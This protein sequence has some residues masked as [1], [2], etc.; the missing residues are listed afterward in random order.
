MRAISIVF[1]RELGAY[2]RSPLGYIVGAAVLLLLGM[3]FQ[4]W[5]LS[6]KPKLSADVLRLFFNLA[7]FATATVAMILSFSLITSERQQHTIILLNTSPIRDVEVILGKY[8]AAVVFLAFIVLSSIYMP[9]LIK[10]NG[11]IS[12]SE[13]V[14]G[15]AGLLMVGSAVIAIGLFASSLTKNLLIAALGTLAITVFLGNIFQLAKRMD[16]PL[17]HVFRE[18][19]LWMRFQDFMGG[20]LTLQDVVYYAAVT[21]FFLLLAV[22]TMEAKRWH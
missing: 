10:V 4:S 5:G 11:K 21:Y 1:R 13:I 22:K 20:I 6:G 19:D 14:V 12:W 16:P 3:L 9:L 2:L 8:L 18:L 7:F 15:Y 17:K